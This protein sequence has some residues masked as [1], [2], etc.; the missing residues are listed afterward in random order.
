[1]AVRALLIWFLFLTLAVLNGALRAGV[2]NPR[3]GEAVGHIVSTLL[4]CVVIGVVA[5]VAVPWIRPGTARS[6]WAI[7]AAWVAATVVFEFG[8]GHWLFGRSWRV[9]LADYDVR[10]GRIWPLVLLVTLLAPPVV[11]ATRGVLGG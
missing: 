11:A 10:Q 8:A 5:W 7:G 6:A 4:L 9:L 2:L 1:M 3:F